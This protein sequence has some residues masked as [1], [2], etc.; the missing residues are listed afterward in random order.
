MRARNR[1][2]A[3]AGQ[4]AGRNVV[5]RVGDVRAR[6]QRLDFAVLPVRAHHL[7]ALDRGGGVREVVRDDL[8]AVEPGHRDLAALARPLSERVRGRVD[9]GTGEVDGVGR[10]AQIVGHPKRVRD[11]G[12]A[13]RREAT[14]E[15]TDRNKPWRARRISR[16]QIVV[17]GCG[18][19]TFGGGLVVFVVGGV[20]GGGL[21]AVVGGLVAGV[22]AGVVSL[23]GAVAGVVSDE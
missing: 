18:T 15:S 13:D 3:A 6:E 1:P 11:A 5:Q 9:D 8:V 4:R 22:V 21:F 19:V 16:G 10:G 14:P 23:L 20:L 12:R 2:L 17:G 7:R